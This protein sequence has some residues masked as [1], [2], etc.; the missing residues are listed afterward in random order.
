MELVEIKDREFNQNLRALKA[1]LLPEM[2]ALLPDPPSEQ[3]GAYLFKDHDGAWWLLGI[4][5]NNRLDRQ[6]EIITSS[7]HRAFVKA[8]EDGSY[9]KAMGHKYPEFWV[10]HI[11]VPVG[12]AKMVAY[13][14]RGF[15]ITAIKQRA[16][17]FYTKVFEGLAKAKEVLG[18]SHG[19]P[20]EF[21]KKEKGDGDI[22]YIV[23]YLSKE[24]SALPLA[25]AANL[26]T[27]STLAVKELYGDMLQIPEVTKKWLH[28]TFGESMANEFGNRVKNLSDAADAADIPKKELDMAEREEALEK[29]TAEQPAPEVEETKAKAPPFVADDED[30]EEEDAKKA[31]PKKKETDEPE[32]VTMAQISEMLKELTD[33]ITTALSTVGE[34]QKAL[35]AR[36]DVVSTELKE[37]REEED[38][39]IKQVQQ[40]P[41]AGLGGIIARSVIGNEEARVDGRTKEAK[42]GPEETPVGSIGAQNSPVQGIPSVRDSIA[43]QRGMGRT[44]MPVFNGQVS[45]E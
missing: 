28:S 4:V 1:V 12:D 31:P 45:R 2:A 37:F 26:L 11:P 25:N 24:F 38:R 32:F 44:V 42:S 43:R 41:W 27:S 20:I 13:D 7:A 36:L 19:M 18:M 6:V 30:E 39:Q 22:T 40:T 8:M 34:N 17:E 3:S 29:E 35:D 23:Q 16:G 15:L 21:L 14:E 33:G 9:E 10:R 5:T